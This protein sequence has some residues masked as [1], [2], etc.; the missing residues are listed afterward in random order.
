MYFLITLITRLILRISICRPF[1]V[2]SGKRGVNSE[3][4]SPISTK[5]SND[6]AIKIIT[7]GGSNP[8]WPIAASR[9]VLK[10]LISQ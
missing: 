5:W 9:V 2:V 8:N 6:T 4:F 7:V 3:I 10:R 1:D